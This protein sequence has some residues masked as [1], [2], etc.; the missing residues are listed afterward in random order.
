M[1]GLHRLKG[2][3]LVSLQRCAKEMGMSDSKKYNSREGK[4]DQNMVYACMHGNVTV[5][6]ISLH[7]YIRSFL[8]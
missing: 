7:N 1:I 2:P 8:Q 4:I 5:K 6:S 3:S